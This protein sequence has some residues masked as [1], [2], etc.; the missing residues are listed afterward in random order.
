MAVDLDEPDGPKPGQLWLD[1]Q[2][3]VRWIVVGGGDLEDRQKLQMKRLGRRGD[4]L[5]IQKDATRPEQ[6]IHL[7]VQDRLRS[8]G[9]WWIAKL[10]TTASKVPS[11]SFR[12]T[13][14]S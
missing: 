1:V 5:E 2:Q 10:D 6:A 13:F 12:G 8:W 7:F 9:R 4:V 11:E 14:I 3:L